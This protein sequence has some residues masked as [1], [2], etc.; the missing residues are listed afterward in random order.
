MKRVSRNRGFSKKQFPAGTYRGTN[1]S[2]S[3]VWFVPVGGKIQ[4]FST[5]REVS[6]HFNKKGGEQE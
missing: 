1:A 4:E 6:L 5:G 2:G 3:R